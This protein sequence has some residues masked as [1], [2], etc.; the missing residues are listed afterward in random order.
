LPTIMRCTLNYHQQDGTTES[1]QLVSSV[2]TDDASLGYHPDSV[3]YI[4]LAED[5]KFP[6]CS[7]GLSEEKA[8]VNLKVE[9][10]VSA[11]QQRNNKYT[12]TMRI[13]CIIL[14]PHEE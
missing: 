9:T 3:N 14:K 8:Q 7:Y 10:R 11:T 1:K 6:V 5:F 12:R 2:K 13:D 4:L